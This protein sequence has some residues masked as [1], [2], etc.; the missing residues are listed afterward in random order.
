MT[1]D[2]ERAHRL[3]VVVALATVYLVWGS[4]YLATKVMV[5]AD[6]PLLA[7]GLRFT[8]AGLLLGAFAW[9]RGGPPRIGVLELRHVAAVAA[10]G[11]VISNGINVLGM[12]HVAS[13]V[14]ALLNATPALIIGW[15]GTFGRRATPLSGPARTGLG[16]GLLGVLLVLDPGDE[17][18]R[19]S[20]LGWQLV[21]L[22]GCTGWSL[23]TVYF[24]N[25]TIANTPTMF[26]SM[27]MTVGG[28]A[29]LVLST[30]VGEPRDMQWTS[31]ATAA[32]LW[33]T[34]M[35]SCLAYSAF[36]FLTLNT[37][38][39]IVGSYAFVNPCIAA[40]LGWLALGE[41]LAPRQIGG[42]GVILLAVAL[43]S[44]YTE[45]LVRLVERATK[46]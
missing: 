38:P 21:I 5:L 15:L 4:S 27:Q 2:P 1:A 40:L 34:L 10:G 28:L 31:S 13:N 23:A 46:P 33:L 9:W 6:P 22:I 25:A 14:V 17:F 11:V 32:F 24:R 45:K 42:M 35:S 18:T 12:Q 20:S 16:L 36:S 7:A 30:L 43:A 37:A 39:V 29:L 44:G 41:N 26:L 19:A 3:R 8:L